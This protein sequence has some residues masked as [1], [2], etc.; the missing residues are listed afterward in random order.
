MF[1]VPYFSV[2][3]SFYFDDKM[4]LVMITTSQWLTYIDIINKFLLWAQNYVQHVL[5]L[6]CY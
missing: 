6:L 1:P 2:P 5:V 3:F 4:Y